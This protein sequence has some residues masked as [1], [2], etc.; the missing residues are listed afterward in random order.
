MLQTSIPGSLWTKNM[1]KKKIHHS[2]GRKTGTSL[3][4]VVIVKATVTTLDLS[5]GVKDGHVT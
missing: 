4:E 2:F 1:D 5:W 3:A